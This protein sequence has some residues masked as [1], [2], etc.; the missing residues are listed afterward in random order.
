MISNH[1]RQTNIRLSSKNLGDK[2][3]PRLGHD[4]SYHLPVKVT[5]L[6]K[7]LSI[8]NYNRHKLTK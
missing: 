5:E 8:G 7:L 6:P 2:T 3:Y 1:A 4:E